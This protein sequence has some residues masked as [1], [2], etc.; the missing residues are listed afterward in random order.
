MPCEYC[1]GEHLTLAD[2]FDCRE[3]AFNTLLDSLPSQPMAVHQSTLDFVKLVHSKVEQ[4]SLLTTIIERFPS[5]HPV[6]DDL[7]SDFPYPGILGNMGMNSVMVIHGWLSEKVSRCLTY[8]GLP[9]YHEELFNHL[10]KHDPDYLKGHHEMLRS[11][12]EFIG[13]KVL[14]SDLDIEVTYRRLLQKDKGPLDIKI[15]AD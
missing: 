4:P 13:G 2:H 15:L 8:L 1:K 3:R 10:V 6:V 14:N 7:L 12:W 5:R 9:F 11:S